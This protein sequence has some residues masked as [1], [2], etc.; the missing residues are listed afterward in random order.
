LSVELGLRV[1]LV[2]VFTHSKNYNLLLV[3]LH[4]I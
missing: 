1:K 2:G 3:M 4:P